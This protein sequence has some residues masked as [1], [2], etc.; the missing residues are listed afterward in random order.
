MSPS[1][2]NDDDQDDSDNDIY[3]QSNS[4]FPQKMKPNNKKQNKQ[5]R[6]RDGSADVSDFSLGDEIM[7][8]IR[9]NKM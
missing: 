7:Q 5:Q 9:R 1:S 8:D 3:E 2:H 4:D 6:K